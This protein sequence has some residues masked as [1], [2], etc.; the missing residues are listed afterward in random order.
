MIGKEQVKASLMALEVV[1]WDED[2]N[3]YLSDFYSNAIFHYA[4]YEDE[5]GFDEPFLIT[6]LF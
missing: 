2:G 1:F 3:L 5:D 4:Y 6:G